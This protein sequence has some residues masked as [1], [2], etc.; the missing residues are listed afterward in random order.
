ML[1]HE[2]QEAINRQINAEYWSAYLY[3][4]MSM[5]A[6]QKA[7]CGFAHW[8]NIQSQ[9]EQDHARI[10]QRYMVSQDSPV[11]L[12]PISAVPT[13]WRTAREMI[14]LTLEHEQEVSAMIHDLMDMA[15]DE[16]DY[17]TISRLQWFVDEQVE[18]E[19]SARHILETM[20]RI[21]G[22]PSALWDYEEYL[23]RR[24]YRRPSPLCCS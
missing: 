24:E 13:S 4:S 3:L 10:L 2:I 16:H 21:D 23:L 1:S 17:A 22:D 15:V 12:Q 9:E 8:F 6:E 14:E 18:E 20:D 11:H 19:E 7:L 5:V